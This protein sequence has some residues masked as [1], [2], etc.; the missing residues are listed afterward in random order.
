VIDAKIMTTKLP[1]PRPNANDFPEPRLLLILLCLF[2]LSIS[3]NNTCFR[4]L[5]HIALFFVCHALM[6]NV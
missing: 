4:N 1:S 5:V 2:V 3:L 6:P